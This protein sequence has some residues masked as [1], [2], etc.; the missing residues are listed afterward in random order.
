PSDIVPGIPKLLDELLLDL[1][2]LEPDARPVSAGEV[3]E[4]LAAI[5]PTLATEEVKAAAAYLVTPPIVGR[6]A[7]L[8]RVQRKIERVPGERSRSVLI[9]GPPGVGRTRLIDACLL[10]ASLTGKLVLRCDADDAR[11][12]DFGV[13]RAIARQL[14]ELVPH[15]AL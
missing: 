6:E 2:R 10:G 7:E 9:E 3:L 11:S 5:D 13:A 4:R 14:F 15:D 8:A 1:L 12:G